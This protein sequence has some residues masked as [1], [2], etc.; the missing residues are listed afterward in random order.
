V[1]PP[2]G[3]PF[4]IGETWAK[5]EKDR[6][7]VCFICLSDIS[8]GE[9]RPGY[10]AAT[11]G[12]ERL[13][14]VV[15]ATD[16]ENIK[17]SAISAPKAPFN[18]DI[19]ASRVAHE[20]AHAFGLGDE[21]GP[22]TGVT[23]SG[24]GVGIPIF[25]NLQ[26]KM[27][28]TTGTVL[29]PSLIKWLLPR[30]IKVGRVVA[31]PTALTG[32]DFQFTLDPAVPN[33]FDVGD[34][35]LIREAPLNKND[36]YLPLRFKVV[37]KFASAVDVTQQNTP[38]LDPQL[39]LASKYILMCVN[40]LQG[41]ELTLVAAPVLAHIATT[42]S[43]LNAPLNVQAAPCVAADNAQPFMLPTNLPPLNFSKKPA[44]MADVLG[45]Y[46]GGGHIDCE[47]Y[48]PAGRCKMRTADDKAVPFC[49]VC[50]YIMVDRV[51]ALKLAEL[52]QLYDPFFP[53]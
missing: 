25:P 35:V 50:R 10:F 46:E 15:A 12:Y 48:R 6:G 4:N 24:G 28:I 29:N 26:A 3:D 16:G 43:P 45:I 8:A 7:L 11:T 40:V 34:L 39:F 44:T 47:E 13:V 2:G 5:T 27:V 17:T 21:Y 19:F 51:E 42:N 30:A 18:E 33:P 1:A 52:D 41:P 20:C 14:T 23:L 31:A 49:H 38:P 37:Q 9:A 32:P 53:F 36:P 22:G